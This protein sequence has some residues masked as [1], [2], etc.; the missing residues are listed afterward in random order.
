MDVAE[1][2]TQLSTDGP[3]LAAGAARADWDAPVPGTEWTVRELVKHVSGVH[4]WATLI[5][6]TGSPDFDNAAGDA[7]GSGPSDDELI[8]WFLD[9]HAT[10]VEALQA[11]PADVECATFLPAPSP[12]AFWSRRQAH[13]TAVHR[14]D[15]ERAGGAITAY[16]ADFAQDGMA[17]LLLGFAARRRKAADTQGTLALVVADGP[18]WLVTFEGERIQAAPGDG[19][20]PAE[21]TVAGTSSD[22]YAWL[23]NRPSDAEVSGAAEIVELWHAVRVRWG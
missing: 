1:H 18:S 14:G 12:L 11:A 2:L 5:V 15:A 6:S 23:W 20:E 17:E 7:V 13:E 21:A 4:R 19:S 22:L 3:L 10:L 9:G 16:P 8:D